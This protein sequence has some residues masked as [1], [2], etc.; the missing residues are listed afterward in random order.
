VHST[1]GAKHLHGTGGET[2]CS[3]VLLHSLAA[4]TVGLGVCVCVCDV[5]SR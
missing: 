2:K 1:E 3:V 5:I 4:V